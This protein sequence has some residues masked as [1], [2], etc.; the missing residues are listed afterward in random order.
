MNPNVPSN[1]I[2]LNRKC[3]VIAIIVVQ[4]FQYWRSQ[5]EI[6]CTDRRK[7]A[8]YYDLEQESKKFYHPIMY[9][10]RRSLNYAQQPSSGMVIHST[11]TLPK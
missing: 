2:K 5:T 1:S 3:Q 8:I 4:F 9:K 6:K 11:G 7:C 10:S